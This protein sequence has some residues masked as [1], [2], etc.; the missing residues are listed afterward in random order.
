M[1]FITGVITGIVIAGA[2]IALEHYGSLIPP[3]G[4]FSF[5]G[6]GAFGNDLKGHGLG[7]CDLH[8]PI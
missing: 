3:V 2:W 8:R 6:N 7:G 5:S 4:P 1:S